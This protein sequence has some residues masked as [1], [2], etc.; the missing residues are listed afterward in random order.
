M[1]SV[2]AC[3]S[4]FIQGFWLYNSISYSDTLLSGAA[5][6]CDSIT[7]HDLTINYSVVTTS[8]STSCNLADVGVMLPTY[9]K[10]G[11]WFDPLRL[12]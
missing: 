1:T 7:N 11:L 8:T 4:F 5:N 6:T 2:I 3:D 10:F 12:R 9:F